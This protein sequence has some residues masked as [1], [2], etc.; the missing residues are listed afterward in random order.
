MR[1]RTLHWNRAATGP[2]CG[3]PVTEPSTSLPRSVTCPRCRRRVRLRNATLR[4]LAT[5]QQLHASDRPAS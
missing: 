1:P 3:A 2:A 5:L 4:R